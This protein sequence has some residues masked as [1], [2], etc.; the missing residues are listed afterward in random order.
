MIA[1]SVHLGDPLNTNARALLQASHELMKSLF[2]S[3]ANHALCVE[4]LC[5]PHIQFFVA[6]LDEQ[7]IG[8]A[9]LAEYAA[10]GEIK[11]MYVAPIARGI[12]VAAL[13]LKRLLEEARIRSLS[14]LRLETGI[15]LDAAHRLYLRLSF[16][17]CP[18]FG[19]YAPD[20]PYSR[21]MERVL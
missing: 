8:C 14:C 12:G 2:P 20:A 5:A 16:V 19:T 21:Y 1:V 9:A 13:L 17:D 15:G 10:Y 7:T 6:D 3:K 18:A 4:R 11:A